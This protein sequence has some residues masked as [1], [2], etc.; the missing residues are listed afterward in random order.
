MRK[1]ANQKTIDKYI[2][3]LTDSLMLY[4]AQRYNL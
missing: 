4:E 1:G 3:G 2:R